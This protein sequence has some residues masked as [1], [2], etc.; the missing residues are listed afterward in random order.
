MPTVT[1]NNSAF[2]ILNL[3]LSCINLRLNSG[4]NSFDLCRFDDPQSYCHRL[5]Q[6]LRD[7]IRST[8][9]EGIVYGTILVTPDAAEWRD[10]PAT[11]LGNPSTMEDRFRAVYDYAVAQ[12]YVGGFPNFHEAD[13]GSGTVYGTILVT[14]DAAEWRDVPAT[15]LGNPSTM[16]DRFRAVYDYAVAQGYVGGFPNFH[17]ADYG[18]GTVYGTI[19]VTPDAAEWRDVPTICLRN[20]GNPA[21]RFRAVYDYAVAQGYV[22]GFPNFHEADYGGSFIIPTFAVPGGEVRLNNIAMERARFD[23]SSEYGGS[24]RLVIEFESEGREIL[25]T[26]HGHIDNGRLHLYLLVRVLP[27]G[28][29]QVTPETSF[30]A[31]INIIGVPN[32]LEG[33]LRKRIRA[34]FAEA[35]RQALE[36]FAEDLVNVVLTNLYPP[37]D[38]EGN[39]LP[40]PDDNAFYTDIAISD[41]RATIS[42]AD[43]IRY[44]EIV[45]EDLEPGKAGTRNQI[46]VVHLSSSG[47]GVGSSAGAGQEIPLPLTLSGIPLPDRRPLDMIIALSLH[48]LSDPMNPVVTS[49]GRIQRTFLSPQYGAGE[50]HDSADNLKAHYRITVA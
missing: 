1:Y 19:L 30:G 33:K 13:Y 24:I 20:P 23:W 38:T 16:E 17:E 10:V 37:R 3:V 50:H 49:I 5:P 34:A 27:T 12:G 14:P 25:G 44:A 29:L 32:R 21:G 42:W 45:L 41:G 47:I 22:G 4:V 8:L 11:E 9:G 18:S 26:Y 31:R 28:E 46:F 40:V 39:P 6:N 43:N 15:E 7:E 2:D 36:P 48:D 35:S